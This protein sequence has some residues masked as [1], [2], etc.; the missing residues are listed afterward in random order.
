MSAQRGV[1]ILV[2]DADH[3][4]DHGVTP[5]TARN[6]GLPMTLR[7][8]GNGVVTAVMNEA[9]T[10]GFGSL[11]QRRMVAAD[12]AMVTWQTNRTQPSFNQKLRKVHYYRTGHENIAHM[13]P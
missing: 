10:N 4:P 9:V 2:S 5:S 7:L 8:C 13:T 3:A 1:S 11:S 12:L 6:V